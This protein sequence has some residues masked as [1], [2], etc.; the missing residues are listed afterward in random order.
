[1]FSLIRVGVVF[2]ATALIGAWFIAGEN[3]PYRRTVRDVFVKV[4]RFLES[5]LR[6]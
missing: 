2:G 3:S 6:R 4:D 1:M 5:A